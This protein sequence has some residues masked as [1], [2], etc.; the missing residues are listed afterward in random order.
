MAGIVGAIFNCA[1][2]LGS[3]AGVAIITSIQT[4]VQVNHG[5]PDGYKGRAA[6]FWFLFAFVAVEIFAVLI[7]METFTVKDRGASLEKKPDFK[8]LDGPQDRDSPVLHDKAKENVDSSS[9]LE[10]DRM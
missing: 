3:A 2:E 10:L 6:A 9:A 8:D 4:S 5:G 1:L 7:F